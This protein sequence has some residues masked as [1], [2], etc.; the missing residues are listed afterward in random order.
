M[1]T[2]YILENIHRSVA[3]IIQ[4]DLNEINLGSYLVNQKTYRRLISKVYVHIFNLSKQIV[5]NLPKDKAYSID[6]TLAIKIY[7]VCTKKNYTVHFGTLPN[8]SFTLSQW[9]SKYDEGNNLYAEIIYVLAY[10]K[11]AVK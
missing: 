7:N 10:Q 2:E 3:S 5:I 11:S 9:I 8:W 1:Q 4:I 6:Y